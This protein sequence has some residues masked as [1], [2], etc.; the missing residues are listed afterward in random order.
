V[1][2]DDIEFEGGTVAEL[3]EAIVATPVTV[4]P[5]APTRS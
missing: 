5:T 4:G 2:L 1:E 3:I